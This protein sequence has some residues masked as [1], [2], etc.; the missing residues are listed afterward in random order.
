MPIQRARLVGGRGSRSSGPSLGSRRFDVRVGEPDE[1]VLECWQQ[2]LE[3]VLAPEVVGVELRHERR[4]RQRE[5]CVAG[6][7]DAAVSRTSHD[8]QPLVV[9]P[10]ERRC[11]RLGRAVVGD[12]HLELGTVC[13]SA[14][15]TASATV[16][17]A[18]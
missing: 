10:R 11:D 4:A 18:L 13:A 14:L 12:D 9:D 17:A 6:R 8:P 5:R 1:G 7:R 15:A 2:V 3:V 16:A